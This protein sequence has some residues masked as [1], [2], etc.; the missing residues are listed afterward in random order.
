LLRR[1]LGEF[2][3]EAELAF[4]RQCWRQWPKEY[5]ALQMQ[6]VHPQTARRTVTSQRLAAGKRVQ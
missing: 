2:V 4:A 3:S 1:K 5:S 6:E